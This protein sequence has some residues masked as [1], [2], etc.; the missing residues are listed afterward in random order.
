MAD[1]RD[2]AITWVTMHYPDFAATISMDRAIG[3]VESSLRED[4]SPDQTE[5]NLA[6]ILL[7]GDIT[8]ISTLP[9]HTI[10]TG[11]IWAKQAGV[12]AGLPMAGLVF[13]VVD[14]AINF[15]PQVEEGDHVMPDQVM[16]EL[17]GPGRALL[18]A[19]RVA[20]NFF[21]R[22]A[23][24]ASLTH[25][26]VTAV[27]GTGTVILDTR[28]TL[29]GFRRLDKYAVWVGGGQNHRIGLF[30]MV[31]IKDNH[32]D[33]AGGIGVAVERVRKYFGEKYPIEVEVKDLID[34]EIAVKLGVERI[35]LDNMDLDIMRQA[36]TIVEGRVPLEA[37]GNVSM[38]RVR[39]IAET[40]VEFISIGA[41]THSSPVFDL[42]MRLA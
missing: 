27:T 41:L 8:S 5:A 1:Y 32:I 12:I 33:A 17:D 36:V 11:K 3:L 42:S 18:T 21:G 4:L 35:M 34:L 23:G 29:P 19:E 28:K 38:E 9:E 14:P 37:S 16:V 24:V 39:E 31:L 25:S 30:D 2:A 40:G 20:L 26:F 13:K 6:D 7:N 22:M 15:V 10:L